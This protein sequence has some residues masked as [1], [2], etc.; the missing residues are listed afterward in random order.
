[1]LA[2]KRVDVGQPRCAFEPHAALAFAEYRDPSNPRKFLPTGQAFTVVN[3]ATISHNTKWDGTNK[4]PSGNQL[5]P[6]MKEGKIVGSVPI[7]LKAE[8]VP[9]RVECSIH[10]WMDGF[11]WSLDHPYAD[12]TRSDTDPKDPKD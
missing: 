6:G 9:L 3:N 1:K 8:T 10:P 4:I 7:P 12:V 11:V 5:L 2:L